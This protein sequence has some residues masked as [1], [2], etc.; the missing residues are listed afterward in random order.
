MGPK[1]DQKSIRSEKAPIHFHIVKQ[2]VFYDFRY[3]LG[4]QMHLR[5]LI[6]STFILSMKKR[7]QK[8]LDVPLKGIPEA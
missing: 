8:R 2:M 5:E 7:P 3:I 4:I 6:F 1:I